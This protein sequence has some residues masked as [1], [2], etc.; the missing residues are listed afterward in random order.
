MEKGEKGYEAA[1]REAIEELRKADLKK[2]AG[3]SGAEMRDGAIL[4]EYLGRRFKV[5]PPDF[6][7]RYDQSEER[8]PLKTQTIILHYLKEAGGTPPTGRL[9]DFRQIPSG[10]FYYPVFQATVERPL[11]ETFGDDPAEFVKAAEK[12]GAKRAEFGSFSARIPVFPKVSITF[13]LYEGDEEFPPS[14]KVLFDSSI[15]DYL[16]I[17]LVRIVCEEIANRLIELA[18]DERLSR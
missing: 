12:L 17:E 10:I 9:I 4:I 5:I 14:S 13:V 7:V 2:V 18:S 11:L 3:R 16:T 1:Y 6:D 8:V 15:Q